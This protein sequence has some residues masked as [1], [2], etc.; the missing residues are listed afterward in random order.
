MARLSI[1]LLGSF[2]V[3][4]DGKPV[5]SFESAKVRALLAFLAAQAGQAHT[6]EALAELLWPDHP[7]GAALADLRH[8]LANLR[9]AIA[10]ASAQPPFLLITQATLQFN[11]ASD[12]CCRPGRLHGPLA[13]R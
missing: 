3:T 12:A 5:T 1:S 13:Q 6:R 8:A 10:D 9:K 4:L 11:L 7:P 2:Q